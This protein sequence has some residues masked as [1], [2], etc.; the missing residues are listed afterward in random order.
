MGTMTN[1][2]TVRDAFEMWREREQFPGT[3]TYDERA[4]RYPY[5]LPENAV[6]F[7]SL[8]ELKR[9]IVESGSHYF[10]KD[11]IRFFRGRTHTAS[12]GFDLW[13]ERF[14]VESRKHE[15]PYSGINEPREYQV[16]WVSQYGDDLSIEKL[17]SFDNL[18]AARKAAK[19]LSESVEAAEQN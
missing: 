9:R 18:P 5:T 17:G 15:N 13:S 7:S 19:M 4:E 10:D 8:E 6:R 16:A 14:W 3:F 1:T 2:M 11:A 12:V